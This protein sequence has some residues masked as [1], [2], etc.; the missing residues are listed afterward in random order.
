[1]SWISLS[2]Q[3]QPLS[4]VLIKYDVHT[5][6]HT[7]DMRMMESLKISVH[8]RTGSTSSDSRFKEESSGPSVC[9]CSGRS[10]SV[11]SN[12]FDSIRELDCSL[13]SRLLGSDV[14]SDC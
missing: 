2:S 4:F 10:D 13:P 6:A 9:I 8:S 5:F 3:T 11:F 7:G 14:I 1:M 12:K